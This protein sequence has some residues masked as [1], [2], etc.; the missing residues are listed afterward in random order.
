MQRIVLTAEDTDKED[1]MAVAEEM[2]GYVTNPD[3]DASIILDRAA[4]VEDIVAEARDHDGFDVLLVIGKGDE[5]W[6][7]VRNRH[8]PYEGDSY[9]ITRMFS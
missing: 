8:V 1:P 2:L 6:M 4:A 5:Q 7:K 3:V 9:I